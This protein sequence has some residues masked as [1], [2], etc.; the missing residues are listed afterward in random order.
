LSIRRV[1]IG[2]LITLG[3]VSVL[4]FD[5]WQDV[6]LGSFALAFL[7]VGPALAEALVVLS[8]GGSEIRFRP[9]LALGV[10]MLLARGALELFGIGEP[11]LMRGAFVFALPVLLLLAAVPLGWRR[12]GPSLLAVLWV[13]GSL[14]FLLELRLLTEPQ[15][16]VTGLAD[17]RIPLGMALLVVVAAAV[18]GGDT[19]AYVVGRTIGRIPMAPKISPRKTWEGAV[20]GFL[21]GTT[22]VPLL[23]LPLGLFGVYSCLELMLLGAAANVAGQFGDLLESWAKRRADVKDSGL[24]LGELGGAFDILDA[25]L[26][27]SPVAYFVARFLGTG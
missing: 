26:L 12:F 1:L 13:A 20:G 23:G 5:A 6:P 19:A 15:T 24:Y 10:A 14:V 27:A 9:A 7:C 8:K 17:I 3:V 16:H 11:G 21:V 4:A 22:L 25:L 18:K 2:C